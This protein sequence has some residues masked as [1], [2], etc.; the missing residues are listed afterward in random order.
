MGVNGK[1]LPVTG[2]LRVFTVQS[3]EQKGRGKHSAVVYSVTLS[4]ENHATSSLSFQVSFRVQTNAENWRP[5]L[6]KFVF[7]ICVS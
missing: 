6:K 3:L 4:G 1:K 5:K 7:R 2:G